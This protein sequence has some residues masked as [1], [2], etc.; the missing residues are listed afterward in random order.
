MIKLSE[1]EN[2][3]KRNIENEVSTKASELLGTE[4]WEAP[5]SNSRVLEEQIGLCADCK[6]LSYCKTE[7][8][9]VLAKCETFDIRLNGQNRI[10]ECNCHQKRGQLSLNEMYAIATIIDPAV[11]KIKGFISVK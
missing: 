10:K 3:E 7:F 2:E 6:N 4:D 1:L 11:T 5:S 8:G 9:S